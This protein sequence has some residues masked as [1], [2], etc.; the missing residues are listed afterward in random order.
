[1]QQTS[2]SFNLPTRLFQAAAVAVIAAVSLMAGLIISSTGAG[3]QSGTV[4]DTAY[5]AVTPCASFDSRTDTGALAGQY[6]HLESRTFQITG[7]APADQQAGVDCGVPAGA[8]AVLVNIV[9]IQ[10]ATGGNLRAF[11]TGDTGTGG[12]VNYSPV[13]PAGQANTAS[14]AFSSVT[15]GRNNTATG[16]DSLVSGGFNNQATA[17][18]SVVSGGDT[19][20]A[21]GTEATVTGGVL[22]QASGNNSTVS[23]GRDRSVTG[24]DDWQ[25]GS[26]F[27]SN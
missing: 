9:A 15:G 20:I 22:N 24:I 2:T 7:T 4:V 14:D 21:S 16:T 12:V 3:A 6:T 8:D 1:M 27:E 10:P 11:A 26:L 18:N 25:A 17:T 5:T 13:T 23:G 19:N